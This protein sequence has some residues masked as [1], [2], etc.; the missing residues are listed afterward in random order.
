VANTL[1]QAGLIRYRRGH[2]RVLNLDGLRENACECYETVRAL[3]DRLIGPPLRVDR[4]H[5]SIAVCVRRRTRR[6]SW[7]VKS[8]PQDAGPTGP[9]R[10]ERRDAVRDLLREHGRPTDLKSALRQSAGARS[11]AIHKLPPQRNANG[12]MWID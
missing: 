7:V 3:S 11:T 2:I 6:R 9:R 4:S 5:S 1:Q 8:I 12:A 10:F